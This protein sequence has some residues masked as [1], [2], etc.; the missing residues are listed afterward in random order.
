MDL[1][2]KTI[3]VFD[4]FGTLFTTRLP[5]VEL[6][7]LV[8]ADAEAL[9]NLWRRKQLEYSWLRGQMNAYVGFDQITR[10]ALQFAKAHFKVDNSAVDDL[11]L[12]IYLNADLL[13]GA[14]ELLQHLHDNGKT[15][16]ILSNGTPAMLK[17]G[18]TKTKTTSFF[19]KLLSVE[20]VQTFKPNPVVY[21][22]ALDELNAGKEDLV[23]LSSNQWD[24]AGAS[25]FG[26]DCVWVNRGGAT[27]EV[28]PFGEVLEVGKLENVLG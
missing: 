13:P 7:G 22:M 1:K 5:I 3:Y 19:S 20:A 16:A 2:D 23:F 18:V 24:V 12:P 26:L 11:L 15:I 10:E 8:G 9:L 27:K 6:E 4:A 17:S 14:F 28:L 25:T 21:Q